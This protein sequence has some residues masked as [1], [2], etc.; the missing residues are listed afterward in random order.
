VTIADDDGD[1]FELA[2]ETEQQLQQ[3]QRVVIALAALR[4]EVIA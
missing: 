1:A 4:G 3:R 2:D